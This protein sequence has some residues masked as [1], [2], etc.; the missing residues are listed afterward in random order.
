MLCCFSVKIPKICS[1]E[2][3]IPAL[4]FGAF[5]WSYPVGWNISMKPLKRHILTFNRINWCMCG[6]GVGCHGFGYCIWFSFGQNSWFLFFAQKLTAVNGNSQQGLPCLD[7]Q[8]A[9]VDSGRMV[10]GLGNRMLPRSCWCHDY[11]TAFCVVAPDVRKHLSC[12][13]NCLASIVAGATWKTELSCLNVDSQFQY[14][15]G[16]MWAV[17]ERM[18]LG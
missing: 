13:S 5:Q 15:F 11:L 2:K 6:Y 1:A 7:E 9:S 4:E 12:S 3:P 14:G 8:L 18:I 17:R 10:G 16:I